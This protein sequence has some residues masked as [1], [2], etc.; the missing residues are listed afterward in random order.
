MQSIH[1]DDNPD[2]ALADQLTALTAIR[3]QVDTQIAA[4]RQDI[5]DQ[6]AKLN[7]LI[8]PPTP[9]KV[10]KVKPHKPPKPPR[11]A[12]PDDPLDTWSGYGRRPPWFQKATRDGIDPVALEIPGF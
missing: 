8:N 11:Y 6:I 10:A 3:D 1:Y 2:M 12:N 5:R 9:A 4:I 7:A